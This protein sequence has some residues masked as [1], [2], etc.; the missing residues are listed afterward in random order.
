[1]PII[2]NVL[3]RIEGEIG[4]L[5]DAGDVS[6]LQWIRLAKLTNDFVIERPC[7]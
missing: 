3:R 7:R 5:G 2:E 1:M 6:S 4:T